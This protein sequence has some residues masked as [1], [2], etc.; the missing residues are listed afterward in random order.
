[1]RS[2]PVWPR[3]PLSWR[4]PP[5]PLVHL[6]SGKWIKQKCS[7]QQCSGLL[8]LFKSKTPC[9]VVILTTYDSRWRD[10]IEKCTKMPV[11]RYGLTPLVAGSLV[12]LW[13]GRVLKVKTHPVLCSSRVEWRQMAHTGSPHWGES[14]IIGEWCLAA[15]QPIDAN[16]PAPSP[17]VMLC[18][19][20]HTL[21]LIQCLAQYV[22][23]A[24]EYQ[25]PV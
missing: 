6:V 21:Q 12:V 18:F 9:T 7:P 5:H 4:T 16:P 15:A 20:S 22:R 19:S 13:R 8:F 23:S 24:G 2:P 1:M 17:G 3:W 10:H 25:W 14:Q 11:P